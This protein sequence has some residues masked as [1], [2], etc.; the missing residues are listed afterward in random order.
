MLGWPVVGPFWWSWHMLKSPT[1]WDPQGFN[2]QERWWLHGHPWCTSGLGSPWVHNA[3]YPSPLPWAAKTFSS[4]SGWVV[5]LAGVNLGIGPRWVGQVDY[6]LSLIVQNRDQPERLLSPE[7]Q[8]AQ[9][10]I[11][12]ETLKGV[13]FVGPLWTSLAGKV[14]RGRSWRHMLIKYSTVYSLKLQILL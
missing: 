6:Q 2:T 7:R 12:H 10:V 11:N 8:I 13:A 14:P 5:P 9:M 1:S 3:L 4:P